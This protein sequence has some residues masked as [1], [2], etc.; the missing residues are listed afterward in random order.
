MQAEWLGVG[1]WGNRN[2]APDVD[3][4]ELAAAVLEVLNDDSIREKAR[5]IAAGFV[6]PGRDIAAEKIVGMLR[7]GA[8]QG[9]K[10]SVE[11]PSKDEL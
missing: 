1:V 5:E 6:R 10:K 8:S 7:S 2:H 9:R 11:T 3:G 4:T